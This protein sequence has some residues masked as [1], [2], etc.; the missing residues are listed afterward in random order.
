[1][2]P[3][4]LLALLLLL[5][6]VA[7]CTEYLLSASPPIY[8]NALLSI[9]ESGILLS[10]GGDLGDL[11][12]LGAPL[13][14]SK[15]TVAVKGK[16]DTSL[17]AIGKEVFY[18]VSKPFVYGDKSNPTTQDTLESKRERL[19]RTAA[20]LRNESLPNLI[21]LNHTS[22]NFTLWKE[23][24]LEPAQRYH[25]AI[26]S[27][28]LTRLVGSTAHLLNS[29]HAIV[30]FGGRGSFDQRNIHI[31]EPHG[32]SIINFMTATVESFHTWFMPP[33]RFGHVSV[34]DKAANRVYVYGGYTL[35]NQT[36]SDTLY[37]LSLD[38]LI[39]TPFN[40]IENQDQYILAGQFGASSLPLEKGKWLICFGV[41]A[42]SHMPSSD[43]TIF[44]LVN[45][46]W[47]KPNYEGAPNPKARQGASLI[48][49]P[50]SDR[51][52]AFGGYNNVEGQFLNDLVEF[53]VDSGKD[54]IVWKE[55][56][57]PRQTGESGGI[58]LE[59]DEDKATQ[60]QGKA[61]HTAAMIDSE[62]MILWGGRTKEGFRDGK[63]YVLNTATMLW[64]PGNVSIF[65]VGTGVM[66]VSIMGIIFLTM[67]AGVM[68]VMIYRWF[69][70]RKDDGSY[71]YNLVSG[72]ENDPQ[73]VSEEAAG[74]LK[75]QVVS[76]QMAE[77]SAS[78][79]RDG[80]NLKE[81]SR[82]G[83]LGSKNSGS[84]NVSSSSGHSNINCKRHST[85]I[86]PPVPIAPVCAVKKK[87]K[88]SGFIAR[89]C[90]V[91]PPLRRSFS[92]RNDGVT[93]GPA[94][95]SDD[96]DEPFLPESPV[97]AASDGIVH[98][99][100]R[101]E[102]YEE[103]DQLG[104]GQAELVLNLEDFTPIPSNVSGQANSGRT[105]LSSLPA[106][107]FPGKS[108]TTNLLKTL[109]GSHSVND[110]AADSLSVK[111]KQTSTSSIFNS[112]KSEPPIRSM[113]PKPKEPAAANC[114]RLQRYESYSSEENRRQTNAADTTY[115]VLL[116]SFDEDSANSS[117]GESR[118]FMATQLTVANYTTNDRQRSSSN[119]DSD[120]L[121]A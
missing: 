84:T 80:E 110:S 61:W 25:E 17:K 24:L 5:P 92:V 105:N 41:R 46:V 31:R 95:S 97:E 85:V 10:V 36:I 73:K 52:I 32:V 11:S 9:P 82:T 74:K 45:H 4:R 93:A 103:V 69:K 100:D 72:P 28:L 37:F 18:R 48:T 3:M 42:N 77:L 19:M 114:S 117:L 83:A 7:V 68:G 21:F 38:T 89:S 56:I 33:E 70:S 63:I 116:S 62:N 115:S 22:T 14:D 67:V 23:D 81:T 91:D 75:G 6:S 66:I 101:E 108:T 79:S 55:P 120:E 86:T 54:R 15:S 99:F 39:W 87:S 112:V 88:A 121:N 29:T 113:F 16:S 65:D 47:I 40:A 30:L 13:H 60:L 1:M 20:V 2:R 106:K 90:V 76:A 57:Y 50:N 27:T 58:S 96:E 51:F 119:K 94:V 118:L 78:D 102:G 109:M 64:S 43:C 98:P 34:Y 44:D 49:V 8:G 111:K 35:Q 12:Y 26:K 71:D 104:M 59:Q 107:L 53:F